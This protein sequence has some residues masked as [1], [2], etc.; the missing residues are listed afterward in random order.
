MHVERAW[1]DIAACRRPAL[2][3]ALALQLCPA[4]RSF[5]SS[6]PHSLSSAASAMGAR[7]SSHREPAVPAVTL[8]VKDGPSSPHAPQHSNNTDVRLLHA[9]AGI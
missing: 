4:R 8:N 5:F 9:A 3:V 2:A 7:L 6:C 1:C